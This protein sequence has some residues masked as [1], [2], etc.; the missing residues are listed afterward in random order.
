MGTCACVGAAKQRGKRA[1][2]VHALLPELNLLRLQHEMRSAPCCVS[3]CQQGQVHELPHSSHDIFMSSHAGSRVA[4]SLWGGKADVT[5]GSSTSQAWHW[6][7]SRIGA[8]CMMP[9]ALLLM[10]DTLLQDS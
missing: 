9:V 4:G 2:V 1:T 5:S 10:R 7:I 6:L 3:G 8:S